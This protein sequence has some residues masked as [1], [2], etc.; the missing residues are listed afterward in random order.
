MNYNNM[1]ISPVNYNKASV[2]PIAGGLALGIASLALLTF[3]S[4]SLDWV[5]FESL[6]NPALQE[7]WEAPVYSL[8]DMHQDLGLV[9]I[10]KF[11]ESK[12][13]DKRQAKSLAKH[14]LK[15]SAQYHF[16]PAIVLSVI[17]A[18]SSYR[19][20]VESYAGARGLMQVK[21]STA[22]YIAKKYKLRNYKH[23][24]DLFD[25]KINIS[26]GVAYLHYLRSRFSQSVQYT[27]AYNLGPTTVAKLIRENRFRLGKVHKYVNE[28]HEHTKE[29]RKQYSYEVKVAY[30]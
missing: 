30:Q 20:H 23:G 13:K 8:E 9:Q 24:N 18:E 19:M 22:A 15:V 26:V 10:E 16:S 5:S 25:A 7:T 4:S 17:Q 11:L 1:E 2:A 3:S 29:L 21:P 28:I 6:P 14:I 12:F 27:A